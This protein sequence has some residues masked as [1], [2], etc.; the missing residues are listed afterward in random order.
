MFGLQIALRGRAR[1]TQQLGTE[2]STVGQRSQFARLRVCCRQAVWQLTWGPSV[3]YYT[4]TPVTWQRR[5]MLPESHNSFSAE[6]VSLQVH[7]VPQVHWQQPPQ[8]TLPPVCHYKSNF[9]YFQLL[10]LF[11]NTCCR[12][13]QRLFVAVFQLCV[14]GVLCD[15]YLTLSDP[16]STAMDDGIITLNFSHQNIPANVFAVFASQLL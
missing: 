14:L 9:I 7:W 12:W 11:R 16:M 13:K 15:V 6:F 8:F 1:Q 2:C 10:N 4:T 5:I 3:V